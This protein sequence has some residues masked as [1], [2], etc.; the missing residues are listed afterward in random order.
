MNTF[1]LFR[2]GMIAWIQEHTMTGETE[3]DT[4][5]ELFDNQAVIYSDRAAKNV[6]AKL[7]PMYIEVKDREALAAY[8]FGDRIHITPKYE[9]KG[10]VLS[11]VPPIESRTFVLAIQNPGE[12]LITLFNRHREKFLNGHG[13]LGRN[14]LLYYL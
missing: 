7:N 9:N 10:L 3:K 5:R 13:V 11:F 4:I 12:A 2:Y 14:S 1:E 8:A 6:I